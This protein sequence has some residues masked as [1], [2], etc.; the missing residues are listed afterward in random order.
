MMVPTALCYK[1]YDTDDGR[2][3]PGHLNAA[4]LWFIIGGGPLITT[5]FLETKRITVLRKSFSQ[6]QQVNRKCIADFKTRL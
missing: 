4:S 6:E 2:Q 3:L 1:Q 5:I